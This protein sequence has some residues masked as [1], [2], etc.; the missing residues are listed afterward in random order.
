MAVHK[1]YHRN[2]RGFVE[3]PNSGYSQWAYI[4]DREYSQFPEHYTRA[5]GLIQ[6]DLIKLFEYIEPSDRNLDTYSYRI[7]ELLMR[8]CIEVEANF[9]AILKENIFN[10]VKRNGD[11][12]PESN[13]NINDYRIVNKTHHLSSYKIHVPIWDGEQSIYLCIRFCMWRDFL[14]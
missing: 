12:R 3:G 13:W 8:T 2:Y 10:P 4:V 6:T 5:F 7:H 11:P 1:P 9:K 14:L